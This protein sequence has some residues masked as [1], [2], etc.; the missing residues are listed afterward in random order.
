MKPTINSSSVTNHKFQTGQVLRL[1]PIDNGLRN[2]WQWLAMVTMLLDHL[3]YL[4]YELVAFR[5]IGRLAMPRLSRLHHPKRFA[6]TLAELFAFAQLFRQRPVGLRVA[7]CVGND[8]LFK[9]S[10]TLVKLAQHRLKR[11]AVKA[12]AARAGR[13]RL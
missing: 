12:T 2:A 11:C 3:G 13:Q 10:Y 7:F 1:I 8:R 5:Y 6:D 4:Y 9:L